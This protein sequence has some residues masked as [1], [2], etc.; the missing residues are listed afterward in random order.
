MQTF[1]DFILRF[2]L[3][4]KFCSLEKELHAELVCLSMGYDPLFVWIQNRVQ[5]SK[6]G[7]VAVSTIGGKL[8]F[9]AKRLAFLAMQ[10]S[11]SLDHES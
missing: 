6:R 5:L 3:F 1:G 10:L 8:Y 2:P 11:V 4:D 7:T 9:L